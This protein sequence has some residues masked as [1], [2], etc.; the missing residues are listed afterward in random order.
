M[1][2]KTIAIST[3]LGSSLM[4]SSFAYATADLKISNDSVETISFRINSDEENSCSVE[5]PSLNGPDIAIVEGS[6]L[7]QACK[8][9]P[10]NCKIEVFH[11]SDC[12][13][14]MLAR[15]Y[16]NKNG[17]KDITTWGITLHGSYRKLF[18]SAPWNK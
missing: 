8:A 14:R 10:E 13:G 1:K 2:L 7:D 4:L 5:I 11:G 18:F 6:K 12:R 16:M 3:I 9:Y 17:V 15:V